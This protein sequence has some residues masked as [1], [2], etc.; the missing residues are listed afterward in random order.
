LTEIIEEQIEVKRQVKG[1]DDY[2]FSSDSD[3][4]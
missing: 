4:E 3:G 1:L 2:E